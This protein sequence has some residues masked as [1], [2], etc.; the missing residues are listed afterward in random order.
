MYQHIVC[1]V[2][3]SPASQ[4]AVEEAVGLAE[5]HDARLTI[6]T[7]ERD[8]DS[9]GLDTLGLD[10]AEDALGAREDWKGR[11]RIA[12]SVADVDLDRVESTTEVL[13]GIPHR[14]ICEFAADT[15]ADLVVLGSNGKDSIGD[16][17][18]GST[19]ERVARRCSVPVHVV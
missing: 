9:G 16:Y 2:D 12:E 14:V 5:R 18:L 1:A 8:I 17:V 7:V 6:L 10:G 15:D 4:R 19:S 11:R 3:G 13:A